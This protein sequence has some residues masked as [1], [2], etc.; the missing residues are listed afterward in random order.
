M[1]ARSTLRQLVTLKQRF[2]DAQIRYV[3]GAITWTSWLRPTDLSDKY[4]IHI[5][6]HTGNRNRPQVVVLSPEL[7]TRDASGLPHV[8]TGDRLCLHMN[9]EWNSTML[10]AETIIPWTLEWLAFY[11]LWL[12]TG[13]WLGGGHVASPLQPSSRV[14]R[15]SR[16]NGRRAS[17][18]RRRQ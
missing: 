11:E 3:R 16:R 2:P 6:W 10:I 13:E 7:R 5:R 18:T 9:E 14:T 12:A 15:W 8:F 4:L 1:T 17:A